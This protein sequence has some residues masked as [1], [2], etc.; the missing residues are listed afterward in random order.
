MDSNGEIWTDFGVQD[1]YVKVAVQLSVLEN[2]LESTRKI[3][4]SE[5]L[6][7]LLLY[8]LINFNKLSLF[9]EDMQTM[10]LQ[11]EI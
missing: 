11:S 6:H 7:V 10:S 2:L 4:I 9:Q 8:C 1:K 5:S 3:S